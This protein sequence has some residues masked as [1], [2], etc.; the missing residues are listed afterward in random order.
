MSDVKPHVPTTLVRTTVHDVCQRGSIQAL[1]SVPNI[2]VV[3]SNNEWFLSAIRNLQISAVSWGFPFNGATPTW[4]IYRG[5]TI[6]KDGCFQGTPWIWKIQPL[7]F[8]WETAFTPVES[9]HTTVDTWCNSKP[10]YP[11]IAYQNTK[12]IGG[13]PTPLKNMSSSVGMI[14]P[15]IWKK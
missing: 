9:D 4:M 7:N 1:F 13:I 15:N 8:H 14:L 12:L 3:S 2:Q 11:I 10:T 6:G 5:K